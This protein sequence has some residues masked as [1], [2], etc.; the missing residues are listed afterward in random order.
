[1][2]F[3][4]KKMRIEAKEC[5][6]LVSDCNSNQHDKDSVIQL[7]F[8]EFEVPAFFTIKKSIL[9]LFANGRTSGLVLESGANITQV[10]P[11]SEGY[12][13]YKSMITN[14]IGGETV[15]QHLTDYI[16]QSR[17]KEL[18]PNFYYQYST[19]QEGLRTATLKDIGHVDPSVLEYHKR[20]IGQEMKEVVCKV[21]TPS[22][23]GY[24][25]ITKT[26]RVS[27]VRT[28]RWLYSQ[29]WGKQN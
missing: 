2:G 11:I 7:A 25:L 14:H 10:V 8:E 26:A 24:K 23:E 13:L 5:G 21:A 18:L 6:L 12:T 16:E 28:S 4:L 9:S 17:G 27:T 3:L 15:T 19:E 1:M 22:E 29:L 20:R